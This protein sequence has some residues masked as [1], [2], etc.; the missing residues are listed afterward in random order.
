MNKIIFSFPIIVLV[1][2]ILFSLTG[3]TKNPFGSDQI[4]ISDQIQGKVLLNDGASPDSI[5]VW[6][7]GFDIATWTN[8]SG[9][10]K[11]TM[12]SPKSQ[13]G[14]G[15][16]G[17]YHLYFYVANYGVDSAAVVVRAGRLEYSHG[18]IDDKGKL[19]ETITLV[20]V[21]DI[22]TVINP[23][24]F[25]QPTN[26]DWWEYEEN[27]NVEVT[28]TA[29]TVNPVTVEFYSYSKGPASVVFIK[30][31]YPQED[32]LKIAELTQITSYERMVSTTIT[33]QSQKWSAYFIMRVGDLPEG[34]YKI[35]PHFLIDQES[36]PAQLLESFGSDAFKPMRKYLSLPFR[37]QDGN[38]A[39]KKWG[40]GGKGE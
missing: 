14:T 15:L 37:R 5:Y 3:C 1:G 35:I 34:K 32:L 11:I 19:K 40:N 39:V 30:K 33:L 10:F 25:P 9:E 29:I 6:F 4:S 27:V 21:L 22:Q 8:N 12:P 23:P 2:I 28:L 26:L 36:V 13:G 18:D 20:K 31:I 24:E 17:S 38:F 16:T 7:Q